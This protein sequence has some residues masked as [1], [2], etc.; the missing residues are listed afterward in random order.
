MN[1]EITKLFFVVKINENNS[2]ILFFENN[3]LK[4]EQSFNFGTNILIKDISKVT[5]LNLETVKMILDK[6]KLSPD[7]SEDET[8]DKIFLKMKII[9]KLKKN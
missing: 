7:I 6:I 9:E 3:S 5:A 4:F 2:K 1:L 8:I